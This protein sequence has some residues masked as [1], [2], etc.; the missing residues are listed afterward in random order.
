MNTA[1]LIPAEGARVLMPGNLQPLPPEGKL[2]A[3]DT[4]W[5][6]RIRDQS[7]AIVKTKRKSKSSDPK[8][9]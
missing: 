8:T 9:A 3:L 2:L 1:Y 5:R 7:V 6:R 4:Y